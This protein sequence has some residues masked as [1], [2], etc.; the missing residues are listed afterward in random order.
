MNVKV[1]NT[2]I[3]EV[4]IFQPEPF[5]DERGYLIESFN[6]DLYDKYLPSVNFVQDNESKSSFGVLRGL[7]YQGAP[8]QQAKLVRVVEGEIQ[9]VAVDIRKS[10]NTYL[11]YVS[12]NLSSNNKKQLYI[13]RGFAHAFLVLSKEAIVCYK[14]DNKFSIDCYKG[15]KYDDPKINIDW[16]L[17]SDKIIL[18]EKDKNLS[19]ILK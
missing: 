12:V 6:K 15:I 14:I 13:P 4:K 5:I 11:D 17:T 8:Y 9:D 2:T 3:P 1:I 10:S 16:Q 19:Y 7:H 18:S